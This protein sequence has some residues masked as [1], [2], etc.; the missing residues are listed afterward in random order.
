V[1]KPTPPE[2]LAALCFSAALTNALLAGQLAKLGNRPI[3]NRFALHL[4]HYLSEI[5]VIFGFWALVYLLLFAGVMGLQNAIDWTRMR[6]FSEALFIVA[7]MIVASTK[8]ILN[9][10]RQGIHLFA[11]QLPLPTTIAPYF[12]ILLIGP[13]LGSLITEPAAITVCALLL[14]QEVLPT[15]A[16]PKLLY[17]TLAFLFVSISIG[18]LLTNFAAPP[19]LMVATHWGWTTPF[20]FLAFGWKAILAVA[21]NAAVVS[22]LNAH[23]LSKFTPKALPETENSTSRFT[24]LFSIVFLFAMIRFSHEPIRLGL[25]FAVFL[26]FY[27]RT[28]AEQNELKVKSAIF[29]GFFLAGLVVLTTEQAFW[30]KPVLSE[31]HDFTL[32]LS[33][34][35]LTAVTDNAALT[36]LA[37]QVPDLSLTA[38]YA[39]VA[40]AVAGGGLTLIANAPNPAGFAIL[41][42][43]F[44]GRLNPST[45]FKWALIPTLIA[46]GILWIHT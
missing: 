8:P 46:G 10:A 25:S 13:L 2:L 19:V 24:I 35:A 27:A 20:M 3:R 15:H 33:A 34:I 36:S 9:L 12:S 5:E 44:H 30:L 40:G 37:G 18:G 23:E 32:Y 29:V 7:I 38:R 17:S 43:R 39:V 31:L 4:I 22:K 16:S 21:I 28:R 42:T 26:F 14:H 11:K 1:T 45:L 6:N 41:K